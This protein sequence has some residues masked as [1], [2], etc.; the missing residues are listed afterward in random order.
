MADLEHQ[1]LVPKETAIQ[2]LNTI[3][4]LHFEKTLEKKRAVGLRRADPPLHQRIQVS[5][6][7]PQAHSRPRYR[8]AETAQD[9]ER[10]R[11]R[12]RRLRDPLPGAARELLWEV[13]EE[14]GSL[15]WV[16]DLCLWIHGVCICSLA[17][18]LEEEEMEKSLFMDLGL[19]MERLL[20]K[21]EEL[22]FNFFFS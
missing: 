22:R 1:S 12:R 5:A 17:L 2:A 11:R 4:Q 20:E 16:L 9:A 21:E 3:I 18:L 13:Q 19:F 6:A 15:L 14:L 8:A 10:S 7:L